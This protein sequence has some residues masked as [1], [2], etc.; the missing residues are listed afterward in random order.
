MVT[1]SKSPP[2]DADATRQRL[3]DAAARVLAQQGPMA[4]GVNAIA[5][6]AKC[7]KVLVY[8]YFGGIDELA[9]ALG[10]QTGLWLNMDAPAGMDGRYGAT[11]RSLLGSYLR[12]LRTNGLVRRILAW[13]LVED[14]APVRALGKAKSLAI[15]EWFKTVRSR[16]GMPP[17]DIDA[18][19]INA[20][21]LAAI[22][23]LAL[24]EA[25]GGDFAGIDL[26]DEAN[27]TRLARAIDALAARA[28]PDQSQET[29]R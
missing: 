26:R 29:D 5:R 22:H 24:R 27:W 3:I 14:S 13:E 20:V 28:Y 10:E 11:M 2:R 12:Q 17:A 1:R 25:S 9:Q 6:E 19:A 18:P 21:L 4:F 23:H 16:A 15:R 7:D 8:R